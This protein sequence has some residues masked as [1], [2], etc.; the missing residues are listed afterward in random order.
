MAT[1][2]STIVRPALLGIAPYQPGEYVADLQDRHGLAELVKLNW[3]E[4]LFA[5]LPGVE[6]A[7]RAD[8]VNTWRYPEQ[9]FAELRE[10]IAA[11]VGTDAS[12][13]VPGHGAQAM[14]G[15]VATVLVDRGDTVVVPSPSYGLYAQVCAAHG[16]AVERVALRDHRMD[17]D[18]LACA[19][20][21]SNARVVWICDPNN[22]TG[23]LVERAEWEA[24]LD[25]LPERCA[26]VADEAYMDYVPPG[27]RPG[28]EHD[29]EAGRPV[30][31]IRSFSKLFG[32][33]GLRLGYAIADPQL[34]S[35]LDVV[36]EPFNVNRAALAAGRACLVDP[37]LAERRRAEVRE[38]RA[39]LVGIVEAAGVH[40]YPSA[41]NFVL[42][43][44][45][46]DDLLLTDGLVARGLLIR[47]GTEF[48]L[49][50]HVRV[51]VGPVPLM[52]RAARALV[53]V[54]AGLL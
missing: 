28:R 30:V 12:R 54:R 43:D 26:V 21:D 52:E 53:E 10:L 24:F 15:A 7:V 8:L 17:L 13:I 48:G 11:L 4:S 25:E 42:L 5:P 40:A 34:A 38:A 9:A 6:E 18:A 45:G 16:A 39:V 1:D 41:A 31:V 3:N 20:R 19:A 47:P 46:V 44:T 37:A 22:P 23:S 27:E 2:W 36:Q 32:L 35:Y 51:T 14:I 49:P 29:V 50:G 33:A